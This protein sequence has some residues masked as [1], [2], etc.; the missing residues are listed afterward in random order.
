MKEGTSKSSQKL[1]LKYNSFGGKHF[2]K[3]MR[4]CSG[5]LLAN[6]AFHKIVGHGHSSDKFFA[7]FVAK[8]VLPPVP[9]K[10]LL[11]SI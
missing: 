1:E 5:P 7:S 3:S 2:L 10:I 9:S 8:M 6:S 4:T 11:I